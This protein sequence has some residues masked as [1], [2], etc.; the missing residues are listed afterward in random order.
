MSTQQT[1][2]LE[3]TPV[4]TGDGTPWEYNV[5]YSRVIAAL[6]GLNNVRKGFEHQNAIQIVNEAEAVYKNLVGTGTP[7]PQALATARGKMDQRIAEVRGQYGL[8]DAPTSASPAAAPALSPE[9]EKDRQDAMN[10]L[11]QS[12]SP[13][14]Q[15][16]ES[17]TNRERPVIGAGKVV[18]STARH[19]GQID[20]AEQRSTTVQGTK[21]DTSQ[22]DQIR[23]L[24]LQGVQDL[25]QSAAGQGAVQQ[26]AAAR[27]K[28]ALQ[29]QTEAASGLAAQARGAERKGLRRMAMQQAS[30]RGLDAA[31]GI[32]AQA[33]DQAQAAQ[34]TLV[35][36]LQ[37]ARSQDVDVASKQAALDQ[38][39]KT[40]QAQ[41][42]A[43]RAAN[44]QAAIN[45]AN[46]KLADLQQRTREFNATQ[47][48]SAATGNAD[49]NLQAQ[50]ATVTADQNQDKLRLD[51]QQAVRD[52]ASGL[53]SE[54][55]RQE[56]LAFARQ[57]LQLAE[58]E[59]EELKR[60]NAAEEEFNRSQANKQFWA[61][62]ITSL[63]SGGAQ[64]GTALIN[65]QKPQ[66]KFGGITNGE[67]IAGEAGPEL[68]IP[69]HGRLS[70]KL[71]AELAVENKPFG[72]GIP[73][74]KVA[75]LLAAANLRAQKAKGL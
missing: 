54:N 9:Q 1:Y 75:S 12:V 55:A 60:R 58:R 18:A 42:N 37:G 38:E 29:R 11:R 6:Q 34:N 51:A 65:R 39:K 64:A 67:T 45:A 28:L 57:Q 49:R 23:N 25:Q 62:V 33:G 40:L 4:V 61:G 13:G 63:I 70:K 35:G 72:A 50:T 68:V 66:A 43:A 22:Q 53:L 74:S 52:A 36:A 26:S 8:G 73:A 48:Q 7:V 3:P 30:Q 15:P 56:Q 14:G 20:A 47:T 59:F 24:Q 19:P 16:Y 32:Q 5:E 21:L 10:V 17:I 71:A 31:L 69:I 46:L 44:D 27:M 2:E 41:L